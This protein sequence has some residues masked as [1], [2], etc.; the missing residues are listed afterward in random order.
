MVW[1]VSYENEILIQSE[2]MIEL[3]FF[4][5]IPKILIT[6]LKATPKK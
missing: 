5:F 3:F 2:L 6:V 4:L 1:T